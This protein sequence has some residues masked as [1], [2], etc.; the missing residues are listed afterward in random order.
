MPHDRSTELA[1]LLREVRR[2]EVQSSRLVS[3]AMAGGYSSVFR[4]AGIEFEEVREY[5][6]GDDPRTVDWGVTARM[7]R[8][9]VKKFVDERELTVLFLLDLSASMDGGFAAW[10]GRQMAAR[11]C[12]CLGLSATHNNDKVGLV[13][14]GDEVVKFVPPRKGKG[15]ALRIVRDCLWLPRSTG[16]TALGS[17]LDFARTAVR[18]RA[19]VFLLSDFLAEGHAGPLRLCARRHDLVAVRLLPPEAM[20]PPRAGL[21]RLRDPEGGAASVFD[22]RSRTLRQA[23][24]DR[25]AAW[26][27]RL[28]DQLRRAR[29]DLVD[30]PLPATPDRDAVARPILRFFRMRELRGSKR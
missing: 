19:V 1:E 9:F 2:I 18:R 13:A 22:W 17:A 29:V 10:S 20:A 30:V 27:Q 3:G 7:G 14:F 21:L 5:S 25:L 23:Y 12:A 11:I 24:G 8:P 15:H 26:D 28:R 6:E 4:G 16:G